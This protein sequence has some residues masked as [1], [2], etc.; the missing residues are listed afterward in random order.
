LRDRT[1]TAGQ[2]KGFE[3]ALQQHLEHCQ[4]QLERIERESQSRPEFKEIAAL[5]CKVIKP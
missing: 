4:A 1:G 3:S 2:I 5:I